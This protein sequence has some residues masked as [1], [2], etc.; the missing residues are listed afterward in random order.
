MLESARIDMLEL[1]DDP[2]F[3]N[4]IKILLGLITIFF[5]LFFGDFAKRFAFDEALVGIE[6]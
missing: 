2:G 4:S 5:D 3:T 6:P 1:I